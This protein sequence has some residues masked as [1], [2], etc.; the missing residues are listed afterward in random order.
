MKKLFF[1]IIASACIIL[2]SLSSYAREF[3]SWVPPYS[4]NICYT[5]LTSDFGAFSPKNVM[6]GLGLQFWR[7]TNTGGLVYEIKCSDTAVE[8]F[9]IKCTEYGIKLLLT[10]YN[11]N[12]QNLKWDWPLA[13]AAFRTNKTNFV[14]SLF[15]ECKRLH[16][17]GVDIDLEGPGSFDDDR[18]AFADFV[19]ELGIKLHADGLLLTIDSFHSPCYNAPNMA[20]WEDWAGYVDYIHSMGYAQLY[21]NNNSTLD[22]CPSDPSEMGKKFFKYS[23]QSQFGLVHGLSKTVVSI[24]MP[25]SNTWGGGYVRDHIQEILNLSSPTG[26]CIW[27]FTLSGAQWRESATW[28][29]AKKLVDLDTGLTSIATTLPY[30]N[31][32]YFAAV[33]LSKNQIRLSVLKQGAYAISLYD[34][35][36]RLL[37]VITQN[38]FDKGMHLLPIPDRFAAH[39]V[40]IVRIQGRTGSLSQKIV[41]NLLR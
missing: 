5:T 24:G 15:N 38:N 28:Q 12:Q 4:I 33:C 40:C 19:K 22:S 32:E 7:P 17:D 18:K 37:C 23:Y 6:N 21:E 13:R 10:V 8:K 9:R 25:S 30:V 20:W 41:L 31:T 27:D 11:N 1:S 2:F 35:P 39:G 16:L 3:L 14:N 26:I 29:L 34:M 36:G